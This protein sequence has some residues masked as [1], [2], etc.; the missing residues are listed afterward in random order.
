MGVWRCGNIELCMW[1]KGMEVWGIEVW[2]YR[3]MG[4]WRCGGVGEWGYGGVAI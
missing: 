4:E 3:G 1:Y 2:E